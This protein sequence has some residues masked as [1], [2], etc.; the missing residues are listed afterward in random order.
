MLMQAFKNAHFPATIIRPSLTY[1][2]VIPIAI[3]G[4]DEF[5][6]VDRILKGRKIIVH[7]DGKSFWTV[8]HSEDFAK[9]FIGLLGNEPAIGQSFHITSDEVLNWNQIYNIL[10]DAIGKKAKIVHVPTEF[11]CTIDP[12]LTGTLKGDKAESVIFDN[13]KIKKFVPEFKATIRFEEGIKRTLSWFDENPDKK[14]IHANTN[15]MMD[16]IIEKYEKEC[17]R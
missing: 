5:T 7:D 8:T 10:A 2:R 4:F 12:S 6:T 17:L 11:I 15:R 1:E 9:G 13:S 16:L 14:I 3:G